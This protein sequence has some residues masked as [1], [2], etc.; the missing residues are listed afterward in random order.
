MQLDV[1]L[2]VE[3]EIGNEL[4]EGILWDDD[5][6]RFVWIDI[7]GRSLQ[8]LDPESGS[9]NRIELPFRPGSIALTTRSRSYVIAFEHGFAIYD[10]ANSNLEWLARPDLRPGVRFNDGRVDPMG[11]FVAGTMV[12]DQRAAGGRHHGQLYRLDGRNGCTP[13]LDGIHISNSLCWSPDGRYMYHSDTPSGKVMRYDY[14]EEGAANGQIFASFAP[15]ALPDGAVTDA[16]GNVWVALWGGSRVECYAPSG[17]LLGS[18]PVR[19]QQPTCVAFGGPDLG[20]LAVTSA[21]EGLGADAK[22]APS[23]AGSLFLFR[24][25]ARGLPERRVDLAKLL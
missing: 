7:E 5:I 14:S 21:W 18:V 19:A 13:L 6:Q 16:L 1:T 23:G 9:L 10:V 15:E 8:M 22:D 17:A 11:Q 20:L 2:K 24:T 25:G 12:E 4:G 3:F